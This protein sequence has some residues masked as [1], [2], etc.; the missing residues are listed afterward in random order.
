MSVKQDKQ[1]GKWYCRFSFKDKDIHR[2]CRGATTKKEAKEI[3]DALKYDLQ[4]QEC[5]IKLKEQKNTSFNRLVDL[6]TT[7][8]KIN[9]KK[10]QNQGYYLKALKKYFGDSKIAN[11]IKPE[12]IE[13][14]KSY[15]KNTKK[16][17]NSSIN[18]YLEILSKMFNLAID[19]KLLSE[20]P[21]S[22]VDKL[23][24]DN[25]TIRF[26]TIDEEKKLFSSIDT[27]APY[28]R[29]IVT[30]AL[31]T[32]MRRGE[33][34]NIEWR[35]IKDG[36]IELLQ[37]KS[38]NV[39]KIPISSTLKNTL[40]TLPKNDNYIFINPRTNKPYKDIKNSWNKVRKD[41]NIADIRFHDLRHTVATRMVA[42]G[43]DLLVVKDILGHTM[44]E[45]T[46]R[47]AHPVPERKKAAIEI[48]NSYT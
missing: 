16:L 27:C 13:K 8:A 5:G 6:Y 9:H 33:I 35:N 23:P 24:E 18:R 42:K 31:Q 26:L 44:I 21:V 7:H 15:L 3:E 38:N 47:Y 2:L 39:R 17:K 20:N 36:Y 46:M 37:T 1:N 45:T 10:F 41:A 30:M 43:I 29:P 14:Y 12:D 4:M 11:N 32:G 48:L 19:N 28:L 22:K 25:L 40:A 34:L